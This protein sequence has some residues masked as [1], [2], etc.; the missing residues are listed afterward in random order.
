MGRRGA[1]HGCEEQDGDDEEEAG[2]EGDAGGDEVTALLSCAQVQLVRQQGRRSVHQHRIHGT[3]R[4]KGKRG[5]PSRLSEP[6]SCRVREREKEEER[7]D[8]E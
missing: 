6:T 2:G 8:G 4:V 3:E 1:D 7:E 5:L